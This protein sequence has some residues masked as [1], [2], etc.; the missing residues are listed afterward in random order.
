MQGISFMIRV[1][2]EEETLDESI[3][4]LSN[5]TIPHEIIIILHCCTDKS[6]EIAEQLQKENDKIK[7]FK[8]E[9]EISRAGYENLATDIDSVHSLATYYNYCLS[10]TTLPWIFKWDADFSASSN[11]I[12]Y[13]NNNTWEKQNK[14]IYICATNHEGL[15]NTECYL[16]CNLE[17]YIKFLFWEVPCW[18]YINEKITLPED[19]HISH[20]SYLTKLKSY[21]K[22]DPW[23][24]KEDTEEANIVKERIKQLEKD[25]G[26]EKP[27]LARAQ[28]PE[29]DG[30]FLAI[31]AVNPSYVNFNK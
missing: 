27:G 4:S 7:I 24:I 29:C 17:K 20:I 8:Y 5:L 1:R 31:R 28:N 2:N 16:S 26:V 18:N 21:W 9:Y 30:P 13:L 3:R 23:Y 22:E 14:Q 6:Q 15:N 11:L 10:K 19:I 25:F 12:D